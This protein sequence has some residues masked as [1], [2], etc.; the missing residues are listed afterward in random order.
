MRHKVLVVDLDGTL[1]SINTFHHF[2]KFLLIHCIKNFELF[3]L[4]KIVTI[5]K[6]R[7]ARLISHSKMKYYILSYIKDKQNINYSEFAH[8]IS[9]YK[10]TI[11][12]VS[13]SNYDTKILA[14]AAPLCYAEIISR[15]NNF[16]FC[17]ATDFPKADFHNFS[18]NIRETKKINVM[19]ILKRNN[20][21]E[22]DTFITDHIDDLPLM[23]ISNKNII[24]NSNKEL[25]SQLIS[26][27]IEFE[28]LRI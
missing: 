4:V 25:E 11:P 17:S 23:K 22:I 20:C 19:H 24:I 10:N 13:N 3:L 6:F 14:T 26:N 27:S 8:K 1:Y 18:E 15:E 9:K 5:I 2:L 28:T 16:H 12:E 7:I 21:T